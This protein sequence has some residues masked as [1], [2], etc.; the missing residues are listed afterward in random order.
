MRRCLLTFALAV[1]TAAAIGGPTTA[2]VDGDRAAHILAGQ[3]QPAADLVGAPN[4]PVIASPGGLFWP[5]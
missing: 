3:R 1:V 5:N 4:M 2:S